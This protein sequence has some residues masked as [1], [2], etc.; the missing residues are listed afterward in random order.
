MVLKNRE[1]QKGGRHESKII[2]FLGQDIRREGK[3][4]RL[5]GGRLNKRKYTYI[6]NHLI[7]KRW[8]GQDDGRQQGTVQKTNQDEKKKK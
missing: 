2:N 8:N 4:G 3:T 5:E 6:K 1:E 7:L